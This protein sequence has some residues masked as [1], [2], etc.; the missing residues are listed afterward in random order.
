MVLHYDLNFT[1]FFIFFVI[2]LAVRTSCK[3]YGV[4]AFPWN[5]MNLRLFSYIPA[6][7]STQADVPMKQTNT[8]Q[9]RDQFRRVALCPVQQNKG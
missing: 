9:I 3:C 4:T 2:L 7:V 6:Q 1:S 8:I 5:T